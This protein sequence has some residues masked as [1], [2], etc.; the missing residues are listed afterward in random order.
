M[1]QIVKVWIDKTFLQKTKGSGEILT[2][3]ENNNITTIIDSLPI[4]ESIFWTRCN[5]NAKK[6]DDYNSVTCHNNY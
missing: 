3:L 6:N 4:N 5:S 2:N 1:T